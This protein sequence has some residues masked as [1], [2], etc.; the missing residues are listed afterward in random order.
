MRDDRVEL[1]ERRAG[2]PAARRC[3]IRWTTALVEPPI[4][5]STRDRVLERRRGHDRATAA[6]PRA[7][8]RPR[9]GRSFGELVA[10]AN[11]ARES[12]RDPVSVMPSASARL[13]I[14]VAVPITVQWPALRD[15]QPSISA[16][17]S[18]V[19]LPGA[20]QVE[21]LAARRCP[22][23]SP[24]SRQRPCSIGP[25]VTM[26]AGI[27]ALAAPISCAGVVLSQPHSST[28]PSIGLARMHLLDVHRHQVA[29]QHGGGLHEHLAQRDRGEL[30]RQ[31]A[32]RP[33]AALDG[34]GHHAAG[35][36][37]SCS[38]RSTSCRCRSPAC[39]RTRRRRSP[40]TSSTTG[41]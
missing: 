9:A 40:G 23:R 17:S 27:S 34:L 7:P 18:S 31:P 16:I 37:C 3:A 19:I 33:H 32:G 26:I 39:R 8:S 24:A 20:V 4:A 25:P 1:V 29:E 28:T 10:G 11:R 35:A 6:G 15:R 13:V 5:M 41:G 36:H 21:Q 30:E 14:V 2:L 38:A 22:S 12:R